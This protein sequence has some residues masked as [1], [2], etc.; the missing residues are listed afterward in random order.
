[1][2]LC[3][4]GFALG[5]LPPFPSPD[6]APHRM[7][8]VLHGEYNLR[9]PGERIAWSAGVSFVTSLVGLFCSG[10]ATCEAGS[11][12]CLANM[13]REACNWLWFDQLQTCR[14]CRDNPA[15][16]ARVASASKTSVCPVTSCVSQQL[17]FLLDP[18]ESFTLLIY[19]R[20]MSASWSTG[21]LRTSMPPL[22]H[23]A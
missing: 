19:L 8:H 6:R 22:R 17:Q 23:R 12:N 4:G 3:G 20:W 11:W 10:G 18:G 16:S 15:W 13:W 5:L 21:S 7:P 14:H 1:M 2:V 9:V